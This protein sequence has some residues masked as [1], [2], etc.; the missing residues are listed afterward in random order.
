MRIQQG[1]EQ[2]IDKFVKVAYTYHGKMKLD[3]SLLPLMR[4][5]EKYLKSLTLEQLQAMIPEA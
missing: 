3:K 2:P 1:R 4:E 5:P